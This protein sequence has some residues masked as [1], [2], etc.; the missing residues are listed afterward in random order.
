[1]TASGTDACFLLM[2]LLIVTQNHNQNVI[3]SRVNHARPMR[4]VGMV[5]SRQLFCVFAQLSKHGLIKGRHGR[6]SLQ[7][8]A[9]LPSLGQPISLCRCER[10]RREEG[11]DS[12]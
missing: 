5:K 3:P 10:A 1:M 9:P 6:K 8:I 12:E 2:K 4:A 7:A 11:T